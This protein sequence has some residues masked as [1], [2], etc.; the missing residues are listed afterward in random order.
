MHGPGESF[1]RRLAHHAAERPWA[2]AY[3]FLSADGE[4]VQ[5]VTYGELE[6]RTRAVA[7]ALE[8]AGGRGERALLLFAPGLD[9]IVGFLGCL[10]AGTV[11]VPAYPP[12]GRHGLGRLA[13]IAL[14]AQPR[15]LLTTADMAV[16][17]QPW[18]AQLPSPPVMLRTDAG[19]GGHDDAWEAPA[20]A[21]SD[22]AFLQ[23]TS[24]STAAPKGVQVTHGNLLHNEEMI[25]RAFAQSQASR[26]VS[27]LPLYHD[28]GLVGGVLQ[29]LYLGAEAVL[30]SPLDFLRR[31]RL[32]LEAVSRYRATT[33]GG[34]DFGYELCLRKVPPAE[35][36]GLDL[37]SWSVAFNGA[38]PVRADTLAR[39][40]EAFAPCGFR[41]TSFYPCYGLAEATLF[42]SG[43][44]VDAAPPLA[45]LDTRALLAGRARPEEGPSARALV[46]CGWPWLEQRVVIADPATRRPCAP[47]EVGEIWVSGPSVAHGYW[48]RP[49]ESAR[50]FGAR[51]V[52]A[53]GELAGLTF[54]RTGDLGFLHAGELY[55]SGRLKDLIIVR[56][57]N[58]HPQDLELTAERSHPALRPGCGAA[59]AL[60]P[61]ES[62][63]EG[64]ER[65]VVVQEIER[66]AAAE[67]AAGALEAL[68]RA[69]AEEHELSVHEVVLVRPGGVPKTS[70]GKV[71][72]RRCRELYLAAEL[73][74]VAR[75]AP[76]S[77][78][79]ET[80]PAGADTAALDRDALLALPESDRAAALEAWLR[81]RA[82]RVLR[83]RLEQI[84]PGQALTGLGLDSLAAIE[85]AREVEERFGAAPA[86]ADLLDGATVADLRARLLAALEAGPAPSR[87]QRPAASEASEFPLGSGQRGLWFLERL[88]PGASGA[89]VAAAA[90]VRG[91][92]DADALERAFGLLVERHPALRTTFHERL[93]ATPVQRV[94]AR[95][96]PDFARLDDEG[97]DEPAFAERVARAAFAPF[98][99]ERGPLL[100]VRLWRRGT[101]EHVLL[102]A[103]HHIVADF[104]SLGLAWRELERLYAQEAGGA[105]ADLPPLDASYADYVR[106]E[107]QRLDGAEGAALDAWWREALQGLGD[108]D[109]GGDRPRAPVQSD[110][111]ESVVRPLGREA[112]A[113]VDELS[114]EL[115]VT[116]FVTL[117]SAFQ[118]LLARHTGQLDVAVGAPVALRDGAGLAGLFG[119]LV[120]PVVVRADA[121]GRPTFREFVGRVRRATLGALGHARLPFPSLLERLRPVRDPS[122]APLVQVLFSLQQA[123]PRAPRELALFALGAAGA[124]LDFAGLALESLP[125][126]RRPLAFDLALGVAPS[127]DGYVAALQYNRDLFDAS[128]AERLLAH[129]RSLLDAACARP[130]TPLEAL[131]LLDAAA[132][133]RLLSEHN[134]SEADYPRGR[135]LDH[136]LALTAAERADA[137]AVQADDGALTY[138]A[139]DA[140]ATRLARHLRALGVN[141]G[142]PVG[143]HVERGLDLAV[144]LLGILKAGGCYVPL[145]PSYPAERVRYML[146]DSGAPV[147]LTQARLEG[148]LDFHRGARVLLDADAERLASY[149]P[150]P[151]EPVGTPED[152]AYIIYTSGS[153]GRPKGVEVPHRA[154]VNFLYSMA[155]RPGLARGDVLASVTSLSFDI[156][157]LELYLPLLLGARVLLVRRET[158]RDGVALLQALRAHGATVMQATPSTW[159]LLIEAGWSGDPRLAALCGGEAFPADLAG[160]LL[161]RAASVWNLYGPTE[162]TIWSAVHEL[163]ARD[164]AGVPLGGPIANTQLYV[165]DGRGE[166]Q[167]PGVA[168]E[169]LIGGDGLARGYFAR[170]ELTAE[171]FV[172]DPFA[173]RPGARL[174]RTGDLVRAR[175]DGRLD[176]LGRLDQQVKVRG[177]R[178]ELG[179]IEAALAAHAGVR[180]AVAAATRGPAGET[181]LVAY[182][183][184]DEGARV[185]AGELRRFLGERLP[186]ACVPSFVVP[187]ER[188]PLTPN[189]KLDRRA[190]PAPDVAAAGAAF[191]APR[192][193][194]ER[195]IAEVWRQ[196]LGLARVGRDDNFFDL[197][198]HSLLLAQVHARLRERGHTPALV[199]L[200]RHPTVAA[201][202]RHLGGETRSAAAETGRARARTRRLAAQR[203]RAA[204]AVVGLAGRFPGAGSVDELWRR[205]CAAEECLTPLR[206]EDLVARG[207][208]RALLDD[209]AYVKAAGVLDEA[210]AFDA[211]YFGYTPREAEL[212]D[213]QHRVFLECAVHAL[214]DAGC[215]PARFGGR[216]GVWAAVGLNT[217][218][219][220]VL[221]HVPAGSAARY[222]AYV[223]ND[224][225][226]V[227]TRVSYE[228]NLKGP[229]LVVQ[230]A[231]SSSLVAVHLACQSLLA[232]ECELALAGGVAV[233]APEG[234]LYEE[235]GILSPDGHCRAFDA[236]A[237]GTVFGSG[238]GL[239]ALKPLEAA[240]R[241][242]DSVHAV[243]LGSAV[244]NDGALKVG[245]TAPGVDG[246][247]E[248]IA[249][250]LSVAGVEPDEIGYVE[251]HG[252]GTALGDPI[253]VEALTQAFRART[254]RTG[255][256]ALGS[257][258]TN[259]GHLD[260]AAGIAG[261]IKTVLALRHGRLPASLHYASPNPKIDF[262]A[263]P[264]FVNAHTREWPRAQRPRRAGVSSFGIGGTNAHVV[265]EEPPLTPAAE[266]DDG[267]FH[268]LL[269]SARTPA[270]L[271]RAAQDLA[272]RLERVPGPAL[273]D[274]ACTTQLGRRAHGQRRVLVARDAAEAAALLRAGDP[275]RVASGVCDPASE[276]A[277]A[278]LLPGQGAQH[279]G[280]GRGLYEAFEGFRRPVD[281]AARRLEPRLGFDLRRVLFPAPSDADEAE[282][283]LRR[284]AVTQPALFVVEYAV[285][286]LLMEWGLGPQALLGHSVGELVAATLAEVFRFE[287]ALGLAA[288][289]GALV[290]AQPEGAML[291]VA[292]GEDE[293]RELCGDE[294]VLAAVNGP[295]ACVLAGTHAAVEECARRL[296]EHGVA[297]ERLRTSHAFHSPLV[298]PA[299]EA[300]AAEV[301]RVERRP[302]RLPFVSNVSGT[303]IRPE[304]A[305]DPAY[306]GRQLRATVR[307][308]D[309]LATLGA[310]SGRVLI[311]VGPGRALASL[312]RRAAALR[313]V[314][315][316]ATMRHAS[317]GEADEAVLLGALG[318]LWLHGLAPDWAALHAGAPRRRVSLP[319]YPFERRTYALPL[320]APQAAA[321]AG[322][323]PPAEWLHAPSWR[324]SA[325]VAPAQ[326]VEP[327]ARVLICADRTGLGAAL[328]ERLRAGGARVA[329]VVPGTRFERRDDD[330]FALDPA[331]RGDYDALLEALGAPPEH[332]LHAWTVTPGTRDVEDG[333]ARRRALAFDSLLYLAQAC[334]R[335][336]P[337]APLRLDVL[338]N[339]AQRLPGDPPPEPW[340]ALLL[341]PVKVLAQEQPNVAARSLDLSWDGAGAPEA[342]AV[343]DDV[344]A[345]LAAPLS[346]RVVVWRGGQRYVPA[347][348]PV[349]GGGAPAL[350]ER[351][352]WLVTGGLGGVGLTLAEDL[353]RRL[354][355]RLALLGRTPLPPRAE[356]RAYDRDEATRRTL[357]RLIALEEAGAEV[358]VLAADVT[359]REAMAGAR[360]AIEARF[361][362]VEGV[363]HAAGVPGGGLVQLAGAATAERVL[364]PKV[365][366]TLV[367]HALFQDRPPQVFALCSSITALAGG[368]GQA[369]YTAANAFLDAFAQAHA[370]GRGPRVVTLNWD[371][372]QDVGMA[373]RGDS[374]LARLGLGAAAPGA[375]HPLLDACL[376]A[377]EERDVYASTFS[378]ERHWVLSEHV[379]AGRPTVPGTT[380]LEM[381][382]AAF[383]RRAEGRAVELRDVAFLQPL[384]V[385]PGGSREALTLVERDGDAFGFRIVSRA[386]GDGAW[387]EH[388]R[389][390]VAGVE[391]AA[392][393]PAAHDLDALRRAGTE[394]DAAGALDARG[395]DARGFLVT[396]PRWRVL[397]EARVG[398]REALARLELAPSFAADLDAFALHPA[399]LDAATGFVRFL[400]AGDYLPLA[401]ERLTL[402]APLPA[403][404]WSHVVVDGDPRAAGELLRAD[405]TLLDDGGRELV[406]IRGF[407][408]K[409]V[410]AGALGGPPAGEA[411]AEGVPGMLAVRPRAAGIPPA[412]AGEAFRRALGAGLPQVVVSARGPREALEEARAF[413]RTRLLEELQ[414]LAAP[415][416]A[417]ARPA[418]AGEYA[419]P[420]DD[421]ERRIA[422]VWQRVLGIERV[423]INDNFFELGGTS[424]SGIQLVSE[425]KKELGVELPTVSIFEASTVAALA[426]R[427]R[428]AQPPE[429]VFAAARDRA[430]RKKDALEAQRRARARSGRG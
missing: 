114:R 24:G 36:A 282:R 199:D 33:S 409:R 60:D 126:R 366:G 428:P 427:L 103:L 361:G 11:A 247:A 312:A 292:L 293:A 93:G 248:V 202:A 123:P 203:E 353:G 257:L 97:A 113:R 302:A 85:L 111:G 246:Q 323:R 65:V 233:R 158:A 25:A 87:E 413:D 245:Y 17:V 120:N 389:G 154:V 336:A 384:A 363:I 118:A 235:G 185:E 3:R 78:A 104:W 67:A 75:S 112:G 13:G 310:E 238:V 169:L 289:R 42:V 102:L 57:R 239:V 355:A 368:F 181:R 328:A 280:M 155:R 218:L 31:P 197:G 149:S 131:P 157:G 138:A 274:V 364:A 175:E 276:P 420:E 244:N 272:A 333:L 318:R 343:L 269:L 367:L 200:L 22:V 403:R 208:P 253:E 294:L 315:A 40:A 262:G 326:P 419:A 299:A 402:R 291:A 265:L 373:A 23:Y 362:P 378:P 258:K 204:I 21:A 379:V 182:V 132:R 70:S 201:L 337:E 234:H 236:R 55:V 47:D 381:A 357:A 383:A 168:G 395:A 229:S 14:D 27:W 255:F 377:T 290:Q 1:A 91:A 365:Q 327:A 288:A 35:R 83:V 140:R 72:R 110:R 394:C 139:L 396:G 330:A 371:R 100:R 313:G 329:T 12:R 107:E 165:V 16:W 424:L 314:V 205:L 80:A 412:Q 404:L 211:A 241:D 375:G 252:T 418:S 74:V 360:R 374:P 99:L 331:A 177:H 405:V 263:T 76:A 61:A 214:E 237:R 408:M 285:A 376:S 322:A 156:F 319:G 121:A 370:R 308:A 297:A 7:R 190:L 136:C 135:R 133:A 206:D 6:R 92:L 286:R 220:R 73:P 351:G 243:V 380:Y 170:P 129:L 344:L 305:V 127:D 423:G 167:P 109:L 410:A 349:T 77:D 316:V 15:L 191:A 39:F 284:T 179:E 324:A 108:L 119:Y 86:P 398:E 347:L 173:A 304:D 400:A 4:E 224:K 219:T 222:Q 259:L 193:A 178:L 345:E 339:R 399:L 250:A 50:D 56:G 382:R 416:A 417:H 354:K 51:L 352:V 309:G 358:L 125:L 152:V 164:T 146:D 391:A 388:A 89:H 186:E 8:R 130:D 94:H 242:G 392:G 2:V 300:F 342:G 279:A 32:W 281:E 231:C 195:E 49:E 122:R 270:A 37:S 321:P 228:L 340:K 411:V 183:V 311:E 341:G 298:A 151:L 194:L 275:E 144:G 334:E 273:A 335:R 271:E 145:D 137:I 422:A 44:D 385:E 226:F 166:P 215:D 307:F 59:F 426:R 401:Y 397:S 184:P 287:D 30:L 221:P 105:P 303:W 207:V 134:R 54:L 210:E 296:G 217:Y 128:T 256:C 320:A 148:A 142:T 64:A 58:H 147:V 429:Q 143:M 161:A 163:S 53:P 101:G 359:D 192:S 209:P 230:T 406:A 68:R 227:P 268:L 317:A 278:F 95:L 212:M 82:A 63:D 390:R 261:F 407:A 26:I 160:E 71:Q 216:I 43:G 306:W 386:A 115:G 116:P 28:M 48:R 141:R 240:L 223:G 249:E 325:L 174:Y 19:S 295:A 9:F 29:P 38:E 180:Q 369:D 124:R 393:A 430:E 162:T 81:A 198:G 189:G 346:E 176:F 34:P 117:L 172:P 348:A 88:A 153:T 301:A 415:P 267:R 66:A 188:L 69:V 425:L 90:R 338:S 46:G 52:D 251:A 260:T 41:A 150:A 266:G 414:R 5:R 283:T 196:V 171:R 213:P 18:A 264:F 254:S 96:A 187:L 20:L 106:A 332:M 79:G 84:A 350:R 10:Y 387:Q 159:R 232:G 277:P 45:R 372:W 225:D 62:G 421:L 98:D 356:W